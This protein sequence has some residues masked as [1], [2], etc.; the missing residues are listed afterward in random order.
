MVAQNGLQENR[1]G[2]LAFQKRDLL[3]D[4]VPLGAPRFSPCRKPLTPHLWFSEA[5]ILKSLHVRAELAA[6]TCFSGTKTIDKESLIK[7]VDSYQLV[8]WG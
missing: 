7:S 6:L 1:A 2:Q 4:L 8:I 5:A 3:P